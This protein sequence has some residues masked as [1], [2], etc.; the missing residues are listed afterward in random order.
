MYCKMK[1]LVSKHNETRSRGSK[2]ILFLQSSTLS[3]LVC[4]VSKIIY[5]KILQEH[6]LKWKQQNPVAMLKRRS[7]VDW[8]ALPQACPDSNSSGVCGLMSALAAH[9]PSTLRLWC[10]SALR[11]L[12]AS[13]SSGDSAL[14]TYECKYAW[15]AFS[16]AAQYC[17]DFVPSDPG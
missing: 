12:F 11:L 3:Y 14:G 6:I 10:L 16:L 7:G 15:R 17:S 2:M 13:S 8:E 5:I 4:I 1:F 9:S